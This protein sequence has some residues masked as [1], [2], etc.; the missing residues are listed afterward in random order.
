MSSQVPESQ[1]AGIAAQ[2]EHRSHFKSHFFIIIARLGF[3]IASSHAQLSVES[4][5][6]GRMII[7]LPRH[8]TARLV[9]PGGYVRGIK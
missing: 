4:R 5:G 1:E 2:K 9:R 3:E 7:P 6:A 8:A